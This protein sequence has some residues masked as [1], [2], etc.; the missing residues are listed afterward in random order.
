M[1]QPGEAKGQLLERF[2]AYL[3]LLARLHLDRRLRGKIDPSDVVQQTLLQAYRA[4][5]QFHGEGEAELASWLRNIL[6]RQLTHAA[7]DLGRGK[8]DIGRERSLDQA[9]GQSSAR[10]GAWLAAD[11]SSPSRQAERNEQAVRLAAALELL[12]EAQREA[13][14]LHYWQG[15]TLPEIGRHLGRTPAAVAGLLHRGIKLLRTHLQEDNAP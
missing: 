10:L 3:R 11:Q 6:A 1:D 15:R 12:P 5:D 8:R 13:L 7:R 9:L 2:R 14:V 4:L